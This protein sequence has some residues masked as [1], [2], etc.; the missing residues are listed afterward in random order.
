MR[1]SIKA[2]RNPSNNNSETS[3][4]DFQLSSHIKRN[5]TNIS[6]STSTK[7]E[8]VSEKRFCCNKC[9]YQSKKSYNLQKHQIT[10]ENGCFRRSLAD[11]SKEHF[12][13]P[14]GLCSFGANQMETLR[15]HL[16]KDHARSFEKDELHFDNYEAFKF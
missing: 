13:C 10:H 6:S 5:P 9:P 4:D 11:V 14:E 3:D 8:D 2:D 7:Q 1:W 16:E 12:Q 15:L